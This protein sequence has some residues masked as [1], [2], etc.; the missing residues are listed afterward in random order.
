MF[1]WSCI[2]S[3]TWRLKAYLLRALL[4]FNRSC[5]RS[6]TWRFKAYLLRALLTFIWS[7]IWSD[8]WRFKAYLLRALLTVSTLSSLRLNMLAW[9]DSCFALAGRGLMKKANWASG[10][11]CRSRVSKPSIL[12]PNFASPVPCGWCCTA[13]QVKAALHS[14]SKHKICRKVAQEQWQ[15]PVTEAMARHTRS[16]SIIENSA[17]CNRKL[18]RQICFMAGFYR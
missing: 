5:I 13:S 1:I 9:A 17:L 7:C 4:M 11:I 14:D 10:R 12:A 6:Y 3:D 18:G 15:W 2:R 16:M 8:T